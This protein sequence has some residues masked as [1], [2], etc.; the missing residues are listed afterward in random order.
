MWRKTSH[1]ASWP[2]N[3]DVGMSKVDKKVDVGGSG[4][5]GGM[6]MSQVWEI[7]RFEKRDPYIASISRF[8]LSSPMTPTPPPPVSTSTFSDNMSLWDASGTLSLSR[9]HTTVPVVDQPQLLHPPP[10]LSKILDGSSSVGSVSDLTSENTE[11]LS[12]IG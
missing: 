2:R 6:R 12:S 8:H 7:Y 10:L 5:G 1:P 11:E 9:G 4:G 3:F